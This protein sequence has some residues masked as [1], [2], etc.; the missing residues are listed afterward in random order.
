MNK[1][2]LDVIMACA[3]ALGVLI[4]A[5]SVLIVALRAPTDCEC[6]RAVEIVQQRERSDR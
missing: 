6:S 1:K 5:I 2:I 3:F 4:M